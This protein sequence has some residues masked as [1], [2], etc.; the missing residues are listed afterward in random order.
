MKRGYVV[1][2]IDCRLELVLKMRYFGFISYSY[3]YSYSMKWYSYSMR[4]LRVR[5]RVPL[6]LSTI[7]KNPMKYALK[8]RDTQVAKF[9]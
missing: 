8:L 2:R 5:V 4:Y 9:N 3:S 6:T 1:N 7:T